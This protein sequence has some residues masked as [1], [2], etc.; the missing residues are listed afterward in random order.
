MFVSN[1]FIEQKYGLFSGSL[2]S[3]TF[4]EL[5]S[6]KFEMVYFLK[7]EPLKLWHITRPTEYTSGTNQN[8]STNF[9][10]RQMVNNMI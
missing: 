9:T 6:H 3:R 5:Y 4:V 10:F 7:L 2:S 1:I 8:P